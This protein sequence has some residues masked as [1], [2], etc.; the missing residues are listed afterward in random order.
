MAGRTPDRSFRSLSGLE[1][2]ASTSRVLNLAAVASQNAG[3]PDYEKSPF[4]K[5][6][7]LNGAVIIKHRLRSDE[8]YIFERAK[9]ISTKVIIP[10]ERTDLS[11]GGRSLFV[12]QRGWT[13]LL[14]QLRG[15]VDEESRDIAL[16]EALDEL[17]SLDPFLLREHLKRRDFQIA[18][19][20]FA[21]SQAD[22]DRM[23]RFVSSEIS[24]LVELAYGGQGGQASGNISKL[25]SLL[26]SGQDDRRLEPLRLTLGLQGENFREGVFSWKGFLY[27]KWVLTSLWPELRSVIAELTEIKVIGPR[28]AEMLSQV[29]DIGGRVNQAIL[30]QVRQVRSTLQIYD[31]AFAGLT[32]AGNPMAFR[33]FLL[34]SPEMFLSL[35]ER[36]G[37]VSHIASFWRYRFP[38]GRP[39][40]VELDELFDI[41]QDF[42]HGLADEDAKPRTETLLDGGSAEP[43]GKAV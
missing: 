40:R 23:Q 32:Q 20:Y 43:L 4:F 7:T 25:V 13:E 10:F 41:L 37:M 28:D 19:C 6:A 16:L 3:D 36:T 1:K 24:K 38:K 34:K 33:D 29:K 9:R 39:L 2:T 35:G 21:I 42:H 18:N 15:S 27:Y 12:G 30:G 17:P 26:L 8:Q 31:D 5:A 11:L 22:V 14:N